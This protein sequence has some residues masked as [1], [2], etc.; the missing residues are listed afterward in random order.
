MRPPDEVRKE[1]VSQWLAKA[2]SD[3]AAAHLL[4]AA[5]PS[6]AGVVGFYAQ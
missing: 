2:A 6:L 4:A 3:L 5:K 1:L